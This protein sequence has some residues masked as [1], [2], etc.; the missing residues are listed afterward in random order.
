[1]FQHKGAPAE[2]KAGL[3]LATARGLLLLHESG[4]YVRFTKAGAALFA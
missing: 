2:Y 4:T 3:D 1:M